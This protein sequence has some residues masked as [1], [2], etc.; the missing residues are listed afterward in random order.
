[1]AYNKPI[2]GHKDDT[3]SYRRFHGSGLIFGS[4]VL[5]AP[6]VAHVAIATGR[7]VVLAAVLAMLQVVTVATLALRR[8]RGLV[9][10][11]GVLLAAMLLAFLAARLFLTGAVVPG[12]L[13]T[14]GVTHALLYAGLLTLFASSLRSGRTDL[15]TTIALRFD[16]ARTPDKRRYTRRVTQAWCGFFAA[17]LLGSAALLLFA[18]PAAWSLFVNVLD[19]PSVVL[20]FI[21]EYTVRRLR[22]RHQR[23]VSPLQIWRSY[24]TSGAR[25]G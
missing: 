8:G 24:V 4:A 13:A 6:F 11:A 20:M 12:L 14:S 22:F 1:M 25:L 23:H 3:R 16:D 21:A 19:G 15:V 5:F 7:H 18:S 9:R 2:P 17:Q 10:A